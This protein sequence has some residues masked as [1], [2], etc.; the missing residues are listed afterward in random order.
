MAKF[1]QIIEFQ[2]DNIDDMIKLEQEYLKATEGKRSSGH[3]LTCADR[4]KPGRYFTIVEFDSPEAAEKNNDNP[5]TK[6][7]AEKMMKAGKG[8][9]TFYNLDVVF[10]GG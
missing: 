4:D 3:G 2:T 7:F 8:E 10:E 1:V 6:A 9:P 5:E